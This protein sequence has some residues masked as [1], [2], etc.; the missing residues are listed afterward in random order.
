MLTD[1]MGRSLQL[2]KK[3]ETKPC[4]NFMTTFRK[5]ME[6]TG[7]KKARPRR[8]LTA[9]HLSYS[10]IHKEIFISRLLTIEN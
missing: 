7:G 4:D 5:R 6:P 8:T 1:L 10:A 9:D 2:T 3:A